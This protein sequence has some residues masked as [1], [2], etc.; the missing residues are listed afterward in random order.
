[1][2]A[3]D[4]PLSVTRSSAPTILTAVR[5]TKIVD[6]VAFYIYQKI[7]KFLLARQSFHSLW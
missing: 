6:Q 4:L 1:M 5:E 2:P 3:D 7:S